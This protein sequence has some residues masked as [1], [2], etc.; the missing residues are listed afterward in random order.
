MLTLTFRGTTGVP[1]E[2][3]CVTPDT[4]AGKTAAEVERLNVLFGN[5]EVPLAEFFVV[6]GDPSD[7]HI[8]VEG[9]CAKVKWLGSGMTTG[10]LEVRGNAGMHLG[11]EMKGGTIAVAGNVSDWAGAEM[12]GGRIHVRG[13]A[14]HLLGAAYR[15]SR[16]GMV[17]GAILVEGSAGNEVGATMRRGLIAVGGACGDFAG[18]SMIAGSLFVFGAAGQRYGAGMKRGTVALFGPPSAPLPSFRFACE[19]RPTFLRLYLLRLREWEFGAVRD[20]HL[21]GPYRRH[22]GDLVA[23]GKGELLQYVGA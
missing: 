11:A 8:V 16:R 23:L 13:N 20:G 12:R 17:G 22:C 5:A 6:A 19:Y 2:A 7:G 21:D 1:I 10:R 14:G 18:V 9:D 3:E 15:G 4:L